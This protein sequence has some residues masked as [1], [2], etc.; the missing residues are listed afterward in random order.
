LIIGFRGPPVK[1]RLKWA[2]ILLGVVFIEN[3]IRIF[4]LYPLALYKGR[5]FEDWFHFYWWHYGQYAFIMIL[6]GLWFFFVA[7]KYVNPDEFGGSPKG[8]DEPSGKD[9]SSSETSDDAHP[10]GGEVNPDGAEV[11]EG[12]ETNVKSKSGTEPS[13]VGSGTDPSVVKEADETPLFLPDDPEEMVPDD[14]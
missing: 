2:G 7:R 13:Q 8:K 11:K 6:F 12:T 1:L 14:H 3:L 5:E 9:E 4:A 10:E